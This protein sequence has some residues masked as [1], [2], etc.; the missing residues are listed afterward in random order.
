[1]NEA[2]IALVKPFMEN[3]KPV[4]SICHSQHILA[5]A[6]VLKHSS[7]AEQVGSIFPVT[8]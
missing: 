7:K 1:M 3:K 4:A 8:L 6:G 2:V 5:A